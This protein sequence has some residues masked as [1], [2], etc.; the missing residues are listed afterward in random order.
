MSHLGAGKALTQPGTPSAS[1]RGPVLSPTVCCCVRTSSHKND[2]PGAHRRYAQPGVPGDTQPAPNELPD[3]LPR[4]WQCQMGG[5]AATP[6]PQTSPEDG[7]NQAHMARAHLARG[8]V[9]RASSPRSHPKR[10]APAGWGLS[11]VSVPRGRKRGFG[12]AATTVT[13][14]KWQG[15]GPTFLCPPS[16]GTRV[17][18]GDAVCSSRESPG[19]V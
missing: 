11:F 13:A 9:L 5:Q 2:R 3:V 1:G 15:R 14:S 8:A 16:S 4:K 10:R 7:T 17:G 12:S 18:V 6:R 19:P